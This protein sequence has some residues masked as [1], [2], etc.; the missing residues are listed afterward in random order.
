MFS[1]HTGLFIIFF[2]P[3]VIAPDEV[4]TSEIVPSSL[5]TFMLFLVLDSS[6]VLGIRLTPGFSPLYLPW[7][8][9]TFYPCS[10]SP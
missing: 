5:A 9:L 7:C 2:I 10:I 3:V 8:Q 6:E 1:N 4:L